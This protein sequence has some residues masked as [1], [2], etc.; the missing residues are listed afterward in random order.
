MAGALAGLVI[1]LIIA[2]TVW[3]MPIWQPAGS[4]GSP[5]RPQP[6]TYGCHQFIGGP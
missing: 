1:A 5:T 2:V 6:Y 4:G 3:Q